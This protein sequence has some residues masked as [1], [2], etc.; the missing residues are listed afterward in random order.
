M[1]STARSIKPSSRSTPNETAIRGTTSTW[2]LRRSRLRR[3][4]LGAV[5]ARASD[6]PQPDRRR[7]RLL[8]DLVPGRHADQHARRRRGTALGYR[9]RVR[10]CQDGAR[11]CSQRDPL[12]ARMAPARLACDAGL[13]LMAAVRR[14]A[15]QAAPPKR[16][17]RARQA[18]T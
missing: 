15:N 10:D 1:T 3:E 17:R 7:T 5:D 13:A 2:L 9:G 6:P 12:L 18:T 4:P 8:L 11:A 16:A 14:R